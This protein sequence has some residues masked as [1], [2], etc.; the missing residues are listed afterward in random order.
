MTHVYVSKESVLNR[1]N[2]WCKGPEHAR[3]PRWL[4]WGERG[5]GLGPLVTGLEGGFG[6]TLCEMGA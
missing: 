6:S 3:R 5:E 4:E 1:G 2:M